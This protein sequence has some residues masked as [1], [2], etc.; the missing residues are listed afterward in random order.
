MQKKLKLSVMALFIAATALAQTEEPK[1]P[2]GEEDILSEQAFT[3]TEAQ[4]GDDD[5]MSQNVTIVSSNQNI[6]ASTVGFLFSPGRFRYR[7]FNQK[8]N[9]IYINGVSMNDME[10]GQFRYSLVGGLNRITNRS[11]EA[12]L[13][14]EF[15]NF[16]MPGMGGSNNFDFRPSHMA[17]GQYAGVAGA[18]RNYTVRAQYA[19]NTGLRPD[20]WALSAS[21]CYRWANMETSNVS[22]TFYNSL[23]YYLGVEKKLNDK[24]A[25]SFVTWGNPTERAGQGASTDEMYWVANDR[26][27]NPY[28]GYQDGKKRNSRIVNDFAPTAMLTWDW[29][30]GLDTKLTTSLTGRYSMYKSTKL[31]YNDCENPQPDYWKNLPS[32]YYDVWYEDDVAGRTAAG[33]SD[34]YRAWTYLSGSEEARQ[35][36]WDRLYYA[37]QQ[38][39]VA[40]RDA[41]YYIQARH[42]NNL[43][44]ALA[45][46]LNTK[47]DKNTSLNLGLQLAANIAKHYLTI[48]DLLGANTFHNYNTYAI[49]DYSLGDPHVYYDMRNK[50]GVLKEGDKFGHDY[51]L[52]VRKALLWSSLKFGKG[53][54]QGFLAGRVGGVTMQR[55]GKMENGVITS[56]E[57]G[58]T[59]YGKSEVG[60]FLDGG[61]KFGLTSHTL[62]KYGITWNFGIGYEYRAPT[63]SS[64]F[65]A[66]EM[67]NEF[68][69]N[70][71]NEKVFS[72]EAGLQY[73]TT[74]MKANIGGYFS[75]INDATEWQQFYDDDANSFTYVS[76]T[77]L[78]KE[79][80]GVEWGVKFKLTS[81]ISVKTLGT[82][83]DAKNV[84]NCNAVYLRSTKG[85]L[86][87][88]KVYNKNM[89]EA[90]TP[91][92][93]YNLT[94]SYNAKGW[95]I[96]I[97]GNYYDRIYL[98]YSPS[99]RYGSTLEAR[100]KSYE[101]S[102]IEEEKVFETTA[103]G[104]KVLLDQAVEQAKGKGGF[105]LDLS[106]GKSIR[107][108]KGQLSVN[109]S[110]TNVLNNTSMVTGGYEQSRSNYS[111]TQSDKQGGSI[112]V[113]NTRVYKF[114]RNPKKYYAY[115]I[116]GMLNIGYRF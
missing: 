36:Q 66:P 109:L 51:D 58:S 1:L 84:N 97:M 46:T 30:I 77:N 94:L 86:I 82:I 55:D 7:A 39:N 92:S 24:H 10:S 85:D 5:D 59:S 15:N 79:Y 13:P 32:S 96:D 87:S 44:L 6:Y 65:M 57:N 71:K 115:G 83:S 48:D 56:L 38:A 64:A 91:L 90:G 116:N 31:N 73:E 108:K 18:N 37:N 33:Y 41:M 112:S 29:K 35:I 22:G 53:N 95:F 76:M 42:N 9:E 12:A 23:S 25:I 50:D 113:G 74:W 14:F 47:L 11:K 67:S 19:Y 21:L 26:H 105:M 103:S 54:Y 98:S 104:E 101:N 110:L 3:F 78:Q 114:N 27:Y 28:W 49:G 93:C 2:E 72:S 69:N 52:H 45:S 75:R 68:V 70:L 60:K 62:S 63:A 4:L 102:G 99:Y 111:S 8:Y 43:N 40:G 106:I 17:T 81:S 107:M 34:F 89:R 20:G 61:V 100:Q 80:Y 16:S 88:R